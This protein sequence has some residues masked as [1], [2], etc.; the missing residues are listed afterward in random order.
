VVQAQESERGRVALELHDNIT[1]M[2]CAGLFRG[3]ALEAN[4][5]AR[6][7]A[8]R[9]EASELNDMLGRVADEVERISRNLRPGPLEQLGLEGAMRACCTEF[10][11]RTGRPVTLACVQPQERPP[12]DIEL[13]LYRILQEAF[14]NIEKYAG[15]RH[16]TVELAERDSFVRLL[17]KD[18]G[19]GFDPELTVAKRKAKKRLGLLGMRERA[20]YVGGT[21]EVRSSHSAGTEIDVRI[22]L[23]KAIRVD[24]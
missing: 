24:G 8:S 5:P 21:L 15:A 23:P 10:E 20:G 16:V 2:L 13:A 7:G 1:Q 11:K 3:R 6:D 17:I 12:A 9:K 4:L 22:P 19:I 18:D 14:K